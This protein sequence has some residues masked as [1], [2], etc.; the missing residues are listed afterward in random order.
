MNGRSRGV[1]RRVSAALGSTYI[2]RTH[3]LRTWRIDT[4]CHP[5]GKARAIADGDRTPDINLAKSS[6]WFE[7]DHK[8]GANAHEFCEPD[9]LFVVGTID[10]RVRRK[11]RRFMLGATYAWRPG[12]DR[13]PDP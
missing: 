3:A 10:F 1:I 12:D 9:G 8:S 13:P 6:Y 7:V 11:F 2:R 5:L 4:L